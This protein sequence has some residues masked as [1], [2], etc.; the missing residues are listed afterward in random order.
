MRLAFI[1][2]PLLQPNTPYPAMPVLSGWFRRQ[3]FLVKKYDFSIRM[4]LRMLSPDVLEAAGNAV[5]ERGDVDEAL[6]FFVDS[7]DD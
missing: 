3:G 4:L 2:P 1:T 5:K 7:L 6:S